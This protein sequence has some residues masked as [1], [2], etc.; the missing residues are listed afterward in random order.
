MVQRPHVKIHACRL[1][2]HGH[3]GIEIVALSGDQV[4][5]I[6]S[7]IT[8]HHR[9]VNIYFSQLGSLLEALKAAE[10]IMEPLADPEKN[11]GS[12]CLYQQPNSIQVLIFCV[13]NV[14]KP[15]L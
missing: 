6:A 4:T 15:L 2:H 12:C 1:G 3:L 14:G 7:M 13:I 10:Q 9:H 11:A 5:R 8:G